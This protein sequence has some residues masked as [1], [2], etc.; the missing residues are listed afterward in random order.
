MPWCSTLRLPLG[1]FYLSVYFAMAVGVVTSTLANLIAFSLKCSYSAG[2][3][4]GFV[5]SFGR[6]LVGNLISL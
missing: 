6:I 3:Y 5:F 1:I 4:K 2:K